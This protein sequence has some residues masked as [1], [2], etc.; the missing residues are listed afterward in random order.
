MDTIS[1]MLIRIKNAQAAGR[2]NVEM[3]FSNLKFALAKI[4]E[5]ENFIGGIEEK[6]KKANH[7]IS[8]TLRYDE[9]QGAIQGVL[10][11]S[12]PGRRLYL[13]K[14][15]IWPVKQGYGRAIISTS[16]G[17][18]T[19]KEAKKAGLGGEILCEIW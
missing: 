17:L 4:L 2:P 18:M 15:Q 19:N 3:P 14:G 1:D 9:G 10:R 13:K 7:K 11:K 6:G 12:K 16:K 5:K 8:I